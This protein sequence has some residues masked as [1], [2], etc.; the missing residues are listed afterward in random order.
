MSDHDAEVLRIA[1]EHYRRSSKSD[2]EVNAKLEALVRVL[3]D[4]GSKL[5]H[6]G[7]VL[8][9]IMVRGKNVVEVHMI[10]QEGTKDATAMARNFMK[11]AKFLKN[12]GVEVAYGYTDAKNDPFKRLAKTI[13]G[14]K[15]KEYEAKH[16]G[17]KLNVFVVEL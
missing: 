12:V 3:K 11:L 7:N 10:G 15:I 16:K 4:D 8:F 17:K 6:I 13:K 14:F 5:V 2:S 9:L 1:T